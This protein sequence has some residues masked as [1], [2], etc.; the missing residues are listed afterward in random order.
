MSGNFIVGERSRSSKLGRKTKMKAGGG[1][2]LG[3]TNTNI[4][5]PNTTAPS[6]LIKKH[7]TPPPAPQQQTEGSN[8]CVCVRVCVCVSCDL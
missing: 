6:S 2:D 8:V 3:N 4:V 1:G 5:S 7:R